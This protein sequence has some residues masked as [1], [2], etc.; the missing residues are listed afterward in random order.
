MPTAS[1]ALPACLPSFPGDASRRGS[2]RRGGARRSAQ[3][4][5]RAI[6]RP[7]PAQPDLTRS[8]PRTQTRSDTPVYLYSIPRR[9][10]N[11]SSLHLRLV[12]SS[13]TCLCNALPKTRPLL[14]K[15]YHQGRESLNR[16]P[17]TKAPFDRHLLAFPGDHQSIAEY[18]EPLSISYFHVT[19]KDEIGTAL[20]LDTAT[21]FN[22]KIQ[23]QKKS[24]L[25]TSLQDLA[26]WKD[27]NFKKD[28]NAYCNGVSQGC[29]SE[30]LFDLG[31]SRRGSRGSQFA[32]GSA[33]S[34]RDRC[35][36]CPARPTAAARLQRM[37][38]PERLVRSGCVYL[39]R[40]KSARTHMFHYVYRLQPL[41]R[42]RCGRSFP[43]FATKTSV[44]II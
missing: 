27:V 8:T 10:R 24:D 44:L 13:R 9:V 5:R 14:F 4:R 30:A 6:A 42:C 34:A 35:A 7:G 17:S 32:T 2:A 41:Q 20:G 37:A 11:R 29:R 21:I 39:Y 1:P 33:R 12:A 16:A 31:A 26:S 28:G 18:R 38:G 40:S 36:G 3:V 15:G 43:I 19:D 22:G 25:K 23:S